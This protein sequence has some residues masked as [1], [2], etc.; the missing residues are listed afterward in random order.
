MDVVIAKRHAFELAVRP[1]VWEA[2]SGTVS[3]VS[4]KLMAAHLKLF[5]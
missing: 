1:W 5:P 2:G 3:N 4:R